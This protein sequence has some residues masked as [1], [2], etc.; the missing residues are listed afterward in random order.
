MAIEARF[1]LPPEEALASFGSKRLHAS[2]AW[3]DVWRAEHET[4]F[5]VAKMA[6]LDLLADVHDAVG[7]AIAQGRTLADF[8]RE[9]TPVLMRAGWWGEREQQDPLTG[10]TVRVQLGSA[11]RLET[12]FRTNMMTAYASGEWAQIRATARHAPYLM[13][14]A[15]GD[16][17]T[18]EQHR[19][20]DGTVLRWD[21]PWWRTHRPPNGWNCR[22]TVIQLGERDLD[23]LGKAGPD[24]APPVRR[25]EWVNKRTGEVMHVPEGIDPGWDYNV[26]ADRPRAVAAQLMHKLAGVPAPLGAAA[27]ERLMPRLLPRV[28]ENF[29]AFVERALEEAA[30]PP[31]RPQG[32]AEIAGV[33]A[34]AVLRYLR[35][36][37]KAPLTA[38]IAVQKA[39]I[40]GPKA[41][42]HAA[43][44]DALAPQEWKALPDLL[45]APE[46]VLWD[47]DDDALVYVGAADERKL[48]V[49]VLL[50]FV[51][52][53]PKRL[54]IVRTAL[55]RSAA[56]LEAARYVRIGE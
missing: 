47:S 4:A 22:C 11:R 46:A 35:S 25:R 7:Q 10:R 41:D 53:G 38:E 33:L 27:F 55:K 20:W 43:S 17:R 31:A 36:I 54:N 5:V 56:S 28:R 9:L 16:A 12:I 26:G 49:V 52:R 8:R 45:A 24:A 39:T 15:V 32:E 13:Y 44:G 23:A 48:K 37:G 29:G 42:R 50:D 6:D 14:D 19:A 21:D 51:Y 2:F 34:P 18:R 3:Q 30:A 40:A 1:D